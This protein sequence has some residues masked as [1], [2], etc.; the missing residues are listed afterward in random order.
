M[1]VLL[2]VDT[3]FLILVMVDGVG[4]DPLAPLSGPCASLFLLKLLMLQ[5]DDRRIT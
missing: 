5:P 3:N 4:A 2:R 1:K